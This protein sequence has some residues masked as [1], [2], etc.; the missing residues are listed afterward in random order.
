MIFRSINNSGPRLPAHSGLDRNSSMSLYAV[1][2]RHDIMA[3]TNSGSRISYTDKT[4]Y[5]QS[6]VYFLN[7]I[8]HCFQM[9]EEIK[10]LHPAT[11]HMCQFQ[12]VLW[13]KNLPGS[14]GSV[15]IRSVMIMTTPLTNTAPRSVRGRS[16]KCL[17]TKGNLLIRTLARP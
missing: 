9:S 15:L 16:V 14:V 10:K 4:L 13:T 6:A 17:G 12:L 7:K 11:V 5:F 8:F 1:L 2:K 3:L